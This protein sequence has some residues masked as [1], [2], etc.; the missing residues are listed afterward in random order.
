MNFAQLKTCLTLAVPTPS[1]TRG[2]WRGSEWGGDGAVMGRARFCAPRALWFALGLALWVGAALCV[3]GLGSAQPAPGGSGALEL[4]APGAER[5]SGGGGGKERSAKEVLSPGELR[6]PAVDPLGGVGG[7]VGEMGAGQAGSR[8]ASGSNPRNRRVIR[9]G[10]YL[11]YFY[12][13][14]PVDLETFM[15]ILG[16]YW[17]RDKPDWR[18]HVALPFGAY[19]YWKDNPDRWSLVTPLAWHVEGIDSS[20]SGAWLWHRY[21]SPE[22][23]FSTLFPLYWHHH[24]LK[25]DDNL[26]V[27]GPM[28]WRTR[29]GRWNAGLVPLVWFGGGKEHTKVSVLPLLTFYEDD[30]HQ[31]ELISPVFLHVHDKIEKTTTQGVPPLLTFWKTWDDYNEGFALQFPLY[32]RYWDDDFKLTMATPLIWGVEDRDDRFG[33]VFPLYAGYEDDD[34]EFK[35]L[36]PLLYAKWR[37]KRSQDRFGMMG[38]M[39]SWRDGQE[40]GL[41]IWPLVSAWEDER[42]ENART[43]ILPLYYASNIEGEQWRFFLPF[44]YGRHKDPANDRETVVAATAY[45][46][47]EQDNEAW[48]LAPLYFHWHAPSIKRSFTLIPG[49]YY[50]NQGPDW[51]TT[52]WGPAFARTSP[53]ES[54]YGIL[55]LGLWQDDK[56]NDIQTL[57]VAPAFYWSQGPERQRLLLGPLWTFQDG[58]TESDGLF[59]LFARY[60]EAD[61]SGFFFAPGVL[62]IR[63]NGPDGWRFSWFLNGFRYQNQRGRET[64]MVAPLFLQSSDARSGDYWALAAP[65][66][67]LSGN[68]KTNE[69]FVFAFPFIYDRDETGTDWWLAPLAFGHDGPKKRYWLAAPLA[70]RYQDKTPGGS[71]LLLGPLLFG[72]YTRGDTTGLGQPGAAVDPTALD[73]GWMGP[74]A[75]S[76]RP[77][78][79]FRMLFPLI[80]DW[81]DYAEQSSFSALFPLL[82]KWQK[83]T[84]GVKRSL[85]AYV[86]LVVQYKEEHPDGHEEVATAYGPLFAYEGRSGYG[87]GA[88]PLFWHDRTQGM[89]GGDSGHDILFPL[90]WH[91]FNDA[92]GTSSLFAP[93]FYS[94]KEPGQERYGLLP[95]WFHKNKT[96][97]FGEEGYDATFPFYWYGWGHN[98][99]GKPTATLLT[100][101]GYYHRDGDQRHGLILNHWFRRDAQSATDFFFPLVYSDRSDIH[102]TLLVAPLYYHNNQPT[103]SSRLLLP[104]YYHSHDYVREREFTW[105]GPYLGERTPES[106]TDILMPRYYQKLWND[107]SVL[108]IAPL[109][110]QWEVGTNGDHF[111]LGGPFWHRG[112][113]RGDWSGGAFPLFWW[114]QSADQKSGHFVGFPLVWRFNDNDERKL[115][116]V[117][118]FWHQ[119]RPEGWRGGIFPLA[120]WGEHANGVDGHSVLFPLWMRFVENEGRDRLTI[121]PPGWISRHE[122]GYSGGLFPLGFIQNNRAEDT[123]RFGLL[124]FYHSNIKEDRTTAFFPLYYGRRKPNGYRMDTLAALYWNWDNPAEKTSGSVLGLGYHLKDAQG[125]STG[126]APLAH[127]RQNDDGSTRGWLLPV[128][129]YDRSA[130]GEDMTVIAGPAFYSKDAQDTDWGL[131]PLF[132]R[133]KDQHKSGSALLPAYYHESRPGGHT[134][135][136][137]LAYSY[138]QDDHWRAWSMLYAGAGDSQGSW[139]TVF[140]LFFGRRS[141]DGS[142]LDIALPFY[143]NYKRPGGRAGGTVLLP[144]YWHFYN[145]DRNQNAR[146]IFPIYWRFQN[147]E[148]DFMLIPPFF[149]SKRKDRLTHGLV[150]FY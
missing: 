77:Q 92:E 112:N 45:Y 17:Y 8:G 139:H 99:R 50:D 1:A 123:F 149:R 16:L 4:R 64:T 38:P 2:P 76:D 106:Q 24:D 127:L 90:V 133:F 72:R 96:T 103:H 118:P 57:A 48:G 80:L 132:W 21:R 87:F 84:D 44:L 69:R 6:R 130:D 129:Y 23:R 95:L 46:H 86:P 145:E 147:E 143:V 107:G 60:R 101:A 65:W 30:P 36:L 140:P 10:L 100:P 47:R 109:S 9:N 124:P 104:L 141:V 126:L 43:M 19:W 138:R 116:I 120:W 20:Y 121:V 51:R 114:G 71:D 88:F 79:R 93:P 108:R 94:F 131:A 35:L 58:Q 89:P 12:E 56:V 41:G 113:G 137:P 110:A 70:F 125:T 27:L 150:P 25:E 66:L 81:E 13:H 82:F 22:T 74:L 39:Y 142:S 11:L 111:A 49:L 122:H 40:W 98:E 33:M 14:D 3:P 146:V 73:M 102:D 85:D 61:G 97:A 5:A 144:F 18:L 55:P 75:W 136:S 128:A 67:Y 29:P 7:D 34:T 52:F 63:D 148:R 31:R 28:Y 78:S 91:F 68:D 26:H 134:F 135:V 83:T 115:T 119:S 117:T 15:H 105:L 54:T 37:D 42:T 62:D 53:Q 32:M 59:P